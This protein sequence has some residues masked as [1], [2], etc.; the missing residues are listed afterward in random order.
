M[1][2]QILYLCSTIEY[3]T[4]GF[5]KRIRGYVIK[6]DS[7]LTHGS[8]QKI[9]KNRDPVQFQILKDLAVVVEIA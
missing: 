2:G 8:G 1:N 6:S 4:S 5:R 9:N 3:N 7:A